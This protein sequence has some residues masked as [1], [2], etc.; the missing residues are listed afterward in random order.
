MLTKKSI[1][2]I[3]YYI[4][5]LRKEMKEDEI[6]TKLF[7]FSRPTYFKWK[8]EEVPVMQLLSKYFN[9]E[10]LEEFL[11]RGFVS[12][13][14]N[15]NKYSIDPVFEDFVIVNLKRI[16][17]LDR[18]LFN[19]FFPTSEFITRHLKNIDDVDLKDLTVKNAKNKF[20]DFLLSVKLSK[21]FDSE[22]KQH[23][24]VKEIND[25]FSDIEIYLILKY[26]YRFV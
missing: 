4:L 13:Y 12:K 20:K 16:H 3:I 17:K 26:P 14:E 1:Y 22:A 11:S 23:N 10:D 18:S 25:K 2:C 8:R 24:V 7:D 15:F 5:V 6:Y 19:L 21:L 9:K